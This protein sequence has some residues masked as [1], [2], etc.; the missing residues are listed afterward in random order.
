MNEISIRALRDVPVTTRRRE[1]I[2]T[3]VVMVTAVGTL[4]VL[5]VTGRDGATETSREAML[6][7]SDGPSAQPAAPA[8]PEAATLTG[9]LP[10][11]DV[12]DDGVVDAAPETLAEDCVIEPETLR[13]GDTGT[14]VSCLQQALVRDGYL[15]GGPS[16]QYDQRTSAAVQR[17]QEERELFVDG[18]AGRETALSIGVWPDESANVI[19]TPP[20]ASGAE[21]EMGFALSSVSSV[22]D[23]APPLPE[24]SG[25]GRRVVYER[26]GQ[27]AWAVADDGHIIRSWLVTGSQYENE[28]PGTHQVYSR[29]E[30]STA[31]N[32]KAILPL[33]IRYQRTEIGHIGFH[34]IPLHVEDGSPYQTEAELGTRRSGGCQR[35]ANPDAAFMWA[36]ADVGTTV[37][38]V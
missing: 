31:W 3:V 29:S 12:V 11:L 13:T 7:A 26:A 24:D 30:Q 17:L 19:R 36:F 38:V 8:P 23:A 32:G 27:R 21:D 4:G 18:V 28:M 5:A 14:D 16:G 22:G 1:A 6:V 20:P 33:M 25:S 37:V 34:G 2:S 10:D 9:A 35:Q 15:E